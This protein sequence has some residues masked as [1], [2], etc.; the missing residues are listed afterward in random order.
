MAYNVIKGN[1][2]FS[3]PSLGTIEDMVDDHSD[4]TISG[5]KTFTQVITASSGLSA[6]FFYGDGS[7]ISNVVADGLNVT[8][9]GNNRIITST[10]T[11]ELN[12]ETNLRFN[13]NTLSI[14]GDI[15]ASLNVS[16]SGFYGDGNNLT[17]IGPS[18]L[19]Y[20]NGLRDLAGNL[21]LNLD[22]S[23]GL[24]V[25][26][27]GLSIHPST[28]ANAAAISDSDTLILDQSG[29]KKATA[30]QVY[31]Y[32]DG[33]LTIP[34][35]AGSNGQIQF[36]DA[37]DFGAS[38]KLKVNSTI[39]AFSTLL[40]RVHSTTVQ[41][42]SYTISAGDEIVLMN[43]TTVA[44]ASLPTISST[45]LGITFTIKSTNTGVVHISGSNQIDFV[46]TKDL[47][48]QGEFMKIVAADFGGSGY[49]WSIISKSGSF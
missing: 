33:K 47:T 22:T 35:P 41:T 39:T 44:T 30:L 46:N 2:E 13:G 14:I 15:S 21:E 16:S 19:N 31:N 8:N 9:P 18:S 3:G 32:V 27:G 43:N 34:T 40:S 23:S 4:Q 49:G 1:V 38:S 11:T 36:Y 24:Q 5:T 17:N 28:L 48:S 29:N 42:S 45:I 20:G 25:N 6:S 37:G 26:V 10:T 7:S 12:A